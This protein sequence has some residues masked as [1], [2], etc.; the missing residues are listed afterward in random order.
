[1]YVTGATVRFAH[2]YLFF[3]YREKT[4]SFF[5]FLCVGHPYRLACASPLP[6][7]FRS[8]S[9]SL[10]RLAYVRRA[11]CALGIRD[12]II[13]VEFLTL[14]PSLHARGYTCVSFRTILFPVVQSFACL[15]SSVLVFESPT[16]FCYATH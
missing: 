4:G 2:C 15:V 3:P 9:A 13:L 8:A 6:A 1:M 12:F 16:W 7:S 5:C 10:R 11:V 14:S